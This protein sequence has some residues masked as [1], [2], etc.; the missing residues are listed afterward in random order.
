MLTF[1]LALLEKIPATFWGVIV[2]SFF[3]IIGVALANS[4]SYQR[5]REQLEH[6]RAEKTKDREMALRKEVF[7]AATEAI[8]VGINSIGRFSD[9]DISHDQLTRD[10]VEKSPAIAK[11]HVIAKTKTV[12]AAVNFAGELGAVYLKLMPRRVVLWR[13]KEQI[14]FFDN[15]I[16]EFGKE[17]DR[18]LE[19][20]KQHNI[21]GIVDK[22][23]W[24]VL[25]DNF[26]FEQ[27]RIQQAILDRNNR[28]KS[29]NQQQLEFMRDCLSETA[30]LGK[31]LIPILSGVREELELPFDEAIYREVIDAVV[32][33]QEESIGL[34]IEK[35]TPLIP[36]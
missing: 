27:N 8:S 30:S 14:I 7:L 10:Y 20:M 34:F 29:L 2:G 33:K 5:L 15:Q 35:L 18:I 36:K 21:E 11:V 13:E 3:T 25:Q 22:R 32:A 1:M 28:L 12:K 9:L 26:A 4:G 16:A 6:E 23:R 19:L 24:N 31:F 17:R